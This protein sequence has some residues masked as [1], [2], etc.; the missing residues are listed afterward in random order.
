V[1]ESALFKLVLINTGYLNDIAQ[2]HKFQTGDKVTPKILVTYASRTGSTAEVAAAISATLT[3]QGAS[4]DLFTVQEVNSVQPYSAV[5]A[6]SAI[7]NRQWLPE[8]MEFMQKHQKTLNQK[9]FAMYSLCMTLAMRNG[10][11]YRPQVSEWLIPVRSLVTPIS[12]GIFAGILDINKI[13]NFGDRLKFRLSVAFGV[14]SVGDHRD[15]D[16][17]HSWTDDLSI[18]LTS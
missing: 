12:E 7:Q 6:G 8:A 9:P 4:I 10:E 15:W 2:N 1:S 3:K 13:P 18:K 17:I 14:W 16:A 11:K 5:V